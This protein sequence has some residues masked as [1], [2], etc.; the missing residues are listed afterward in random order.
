MQ[1]G[2]QIET[3]EWVCGFSIS[4]L[5]RCT[6]SLLLMSIFAS[7][8]GV[9]RPL[10]FTHTRAHTHT[11]LQDRPENTDVPVRKSNES[12]DATRFDPRDE[13]KRSGSLLLSVETKQ[14]AN[15][16]QTRAG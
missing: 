15:S 10:L 5:L 9:W 14:K 13:L 3:C 11:L 12:T 16:N 8:G 4:E 2:Y 1:E 7:K 6:E